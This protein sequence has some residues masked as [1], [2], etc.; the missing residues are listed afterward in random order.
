LHSNIIIST[1]ATDNSIN[2][3]WPK[4]TDIIDEEVTLEDS[5]AGGL[6]CP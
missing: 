4:F 2:P 3:R 5:G 1:F 6:S